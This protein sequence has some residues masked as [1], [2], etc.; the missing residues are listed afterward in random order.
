MMDKFPSNND[1]RFS[2][3]FKNIPSGRNKQS[4]QQL[5]FVPSSL[6]GSGHFSGT[7]RLISD[8]SRGL[9]VRARE[10]DRSGPFWNWWNSPGFTQR[11]LKNIIL[12]FNRAF[13]RWPPTFE[14][15]KKKKRKKKQSDDDDDDNNNNKKGKKDK[16]KDDGKGGK[17]NK[18]G[19]KKKDD[20]DDDE[21]QDYYNMDDERNTFLHRMGWGRLPGG[22]SRNWYVWSAFV[23]MLFLANEVIIQPWLYYMKSFEMKIEDLPRGD[24]M[25]DMKA[26]EKSEKSI[27]KFY[28]ELGYKRGDAPRAPD[29]IP[30]NME[31]IFASPMSYGSTQDDK[32][33]AL[34]ANLEKR[35]YK[36]LSKYNLA[37]H[38]ERRK[39]YSVFDGT[40][41]GYRSTFWDINF[42]D[43]E[44][45]KVNPEET[46]VSVNFPSGSYEKRGLP[47][48]SDPSKPFLERLR[49]NTKGAIDSIISKTKQGV[50][51][52][53]DGSAQEIEKLKR[54]AK[55]EKEM[56][57]KGE[58]IEG[59]LAITKLARKEFPGMVDKHGN[60]Y[61]PEPEYETDPDFYKDP[62]FDKMLDALN[63][64]VPHGSRPP[65]SKPY[66]P[67]GSD[68]E[69][70]PCVF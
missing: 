43:E 11:F 51:G 55:K 54:Q 64:N 47:S 18:Q 61:F 32:R 3:L 12:Q 13:G 63:V 7:T 66:K 26:Q 31:Q 53:M 15:K 9:G 50:G 29:G 69:A 4:S 27:M 5:P 14:V 59:E 35:A 42:Q 19:R 68:F 30:E 56:I 23:G 20:D 38:E 49:D 24:Q 6:P 33:K 52:V 10:P 46:Q 70:D 21:E 22:R 1:R 39:E 25:A 17:K 62:D 16:K 2:H 44:Y 58:V 28:K 67:K 36:S 57:M 41:T 8:I 37:D 48:T 34:R 40:K 60:M 45:K 65:G